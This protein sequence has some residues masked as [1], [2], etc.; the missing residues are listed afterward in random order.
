MARASFHAT[1]T[2]CTVVPTTAQV[3]QFT[4]VLAVEGQLWLELGHIHGTDM[5]PMVTSAMNQR[6][7]HWR[8]LM[9]LLERRTFSVLL[10]VLYCP[11]STLQLRTTF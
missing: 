10:Q 11:S 6:Y 1:L 8:G 3:A 4:V 7:N 5:V 9:D 2:K